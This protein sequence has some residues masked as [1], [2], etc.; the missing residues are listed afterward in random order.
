MS[1]LSLEKEGELEIKLATFPG[2]LRRQGNSRKNT[3]FYFINYAEAF[4]HVDHNKLWKA[5]KETGLR[6]LPV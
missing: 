2:L 4:D 3:Y 5:L 1:K 6:I